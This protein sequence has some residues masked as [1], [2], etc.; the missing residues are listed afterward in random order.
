MFNFATPRPYCA[1]FMLWC[2]AMLVLIARDWSADRSFYAKN[3]WNF[4]IDSGKKLY[5]GSTYLRLGEMSNRDRCL[6]GYPRAIAVL[7]A[8][9]A[10]STL[11]FSIS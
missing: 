8:M 9:L 3:N 7:L 11:A 10:I 5:W 2:I 4:D 1:L 6:R